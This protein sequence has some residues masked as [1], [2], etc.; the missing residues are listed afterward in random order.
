MSMSVK[1]P[2]SAMDSGPL[3]PVFHPGSVAIIGASSDPTKRGHQAVRAL[4]EAGYAG[5]IVPVHPAGGTLL[6]L[7]VARGPDELESPP[8]LV[9]VCT[10]GSTVLTVLETW[11]AAGARGAVVLAA[12]FAEAGMEGAA[13]EAAIRDVVRRTGIRVVGPNTSGLMNPRIGLNLIGMRD[14]HA[15]PLA[16]LVQSGNMAL[17]LVTEASARSGRGFSVVVG[18]GNNTDIQFSEYVEYLAA[19]AD[20]RAIL[21]HVEGFRDGRG[22]LEA[23]RRITPRKPI[24]L[25]KGA[26]TASGGRTARSHTA[27]IAGSWDVLRAGLRQAGVIE[28]GRA[29]ELFHIG[30]TLATQPAPA[31]GRGFAI[32]SD[33]GGHA[34]LAV[35]ALQERGI[36]VAELAPA[37][38]GR[39]RELLGPTAAEG[40]PVD[41][42]GAADRDP[43]MFPRT[44]EVLLAD[45][46]VGGVLVVGLFGG[47]AIRFAESLLPAEVDAARE[48]AAIARRAGAALIVHSLYADRR[49][50][51]L[52][53]LAEATVPV[54]ESLDVAC[55][56]LEA[57][58]RRSRLLARDSGRT[59]P[60]DLRPANAADAAAPD[61]EPILTAR[62]EGR[63]TLLEP[64]VRSLLAQ[65]GV[66]LIP[67]TFCRTA[68]EA[69]AAA[70]A[71]GGTVAVRVVSPAAP[72]KTDADGV[73]LGVSGDDEVA[74][75]FWLVKVG[76]EAYATR[77]GVAADVRGVL[78]SPM[79][80]RPIAEMLI[81]VMHDPQFGSV[82]TVGAG[83]IAVEIKRDVALRLIPLDA[84]EVDE[85]IA[86]LRIAPVLDGIR[87]RPPACRA[88]IVAAALG[89]AR[90]AVE[91][92]AIA[93]I[94]V[95]PLFVYADR[96]V[97][98][99]ARAYLH[100]G[101]E[102]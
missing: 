80:E 85:M 73:L 81:G 48:M 36:D 55:S 72:H 41:L 11:A 22:F 69:V 77:R 47:Y 6:G 49:T 65:V 26:R 21:M 93:E 10:P 2:A 57:L 97:A 70:H 79:A 37:T 35:D 38:R 58:L 23:A 84:A 15:G 64:D 89:V 83:G 39:L 18:V 96:V 54:V 43:A 102:G 71:A 66:P 92:P 17:Q 4:L 101:T 61:A 27:S 16:L 87:G 33:G 8:D 95:N 42:A 62:A 59:N 12:G 40:N 3:D 51:P 53:Q 46:A 25:L 29:D 5:R 32:L 86:E 76:V 63:S 34:T 9:L 82:L 99:D 1:Y 28:V 30:E 94:E 7:P 50:E 45:P 91:N 56:C 68:A 31:V 20:T 19:D 24:V 13:A 60:W 90:A 74:A 14:V 78:V 67:A 98:L 52:L 44:L 100:R 88:G 75:A